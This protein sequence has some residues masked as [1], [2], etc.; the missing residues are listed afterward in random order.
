MA[1]TGCFVFDEINKGMAL[2]DEHSAG[3]SAKKAKESEPESDSLGESILAELPE[4]KARLVEW[5]RNALEE[6]PPAPDPND[7]IVRCVV[8]S[9]VS[10]TRKS[11]CTIR[12][13]HFVSR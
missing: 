11:D 5:W 13:G 10:F 1:L 12:G 3:G 4:M 9:K 2:M 7:G 6:E 8:G